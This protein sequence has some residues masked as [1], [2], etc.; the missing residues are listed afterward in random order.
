[1][2]SDFDAIENHRLDKFCKQALGISLLPSSPT[3]RQRRDAQADAVSQHVLPMIET[4]LTRRAPS[5][6]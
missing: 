3:L 2:K 1:A 5:S 4:L 6:A